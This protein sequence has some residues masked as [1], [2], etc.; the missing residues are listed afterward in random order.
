[1][2][3]KKPKTSAKSTKTTKSTKPKTAAKPVT[4]V[5]AP[6]KTKTV[7]KEVTSEANKSCFKG[8]FSRKYE[9]K[10]SILTVFKRPKFYGAL[11]GEVLGTALLTL[12]LFSLSFASLANIATFGLALVAILIAVYAFSGACL[13]PIVTVGMMA[14]RRMSVIRGIMY[15]IA[16]VVGAW[17]G[18]LI[19][20]SFHMAGG[21]TASAVPT[22]TAIEE[23]QFWLF[24]MVELLGAVIIAFIF[25]RALKYKRSVFTFAVTATGG[26]ILAVLAGY[27]VS[28]A[29]LG[30][31][32][33][34]IFNPAV[35]LMYQIFPTSGDGFGEIMGGVCQ[36]LSVYAL[37]PMIGGVVGFYLSD[38]MGKL[39]CEE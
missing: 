29:L 6:A 1:M 25:A 15:I 9:E 19:F 27:M 11:L 28:A 2:A 26:V 5:A 7:E 16:E 14:S 31:N 12:L 39:S 4:S 13:N 32:N 37:L 17:L 35:A 8:F 38:F 20:N 33:N 34:F 3:T 24:A 22:L 30:L 18:W 10:E 36:A 23:G 21:E